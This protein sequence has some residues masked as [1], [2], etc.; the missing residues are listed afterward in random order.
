MSGSPADD[1]KTDENTTST[2]TNSVI[3]PQKKVL[4]TASSPGLTSISSFDAHDEAQRIYQ[5]LFGLQSKS[6][7]KELI[8]SGDLLREI[9]SAICVNHNQDDKENEPLSC[10]SILA[11]ATKSDGEM[12]NEI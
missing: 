1:A 8:T 4:N 2:I 11:M 3:T 12:L 10:S 6:M 9:Y 5:L 7:E